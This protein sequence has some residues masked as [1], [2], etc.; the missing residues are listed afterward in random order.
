MPRICNLQT[1]QSTGNERYSKQASFG[2]AD[3]DNL[4]KQQ[5]EPGSPKTRWRFPGRDGDSAKLKWRLTIRSVKFVRSGTDSPQGT[6]MIT[7]GGKIAGARA[8]TGAQEAEHVTCRGP[9]GPSGGRRS[10]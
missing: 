8:Q 3:S 9:S 4:Q 2:G 10:A 7:T 6:N 1:L 5:Q